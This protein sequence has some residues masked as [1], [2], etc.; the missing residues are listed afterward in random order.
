[1]TIFKG[2]DGCLPLHFVVKY[3]PEVVRSTSEL[4]NTE[5]NEDEKRD[6]VLSFSEDAFIETLKYLID[7]TIKYADTKSETK[8]LKSVSD[9]DNI[10][11]SDDL[12]GDSPL[13]YAVAR[14]NIKAAEILLEK[15]A[16]P[17]DV[18]KQSTTPLY[19]AAKNGDVEMLKLLLQYKGDLS[20]SDEDDTTPLQSWVVFLLK[21]SS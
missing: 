2:D 19:M 1:M 8:S 17:N 16:N 7:E 6:R 20:I 12:Y 14:S 15:G 3:R 21:Y 4:E 11:D 5:P 13:H 18:D 9:E 10:I